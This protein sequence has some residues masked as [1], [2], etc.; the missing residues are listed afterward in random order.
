VNRRPQVAA[1]GVAD[2]AKPRL[3][4]DFFEKSS[5]ARSVFTLRIVLA[6]SERLNAIIVSPVSSA[7]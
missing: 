6:V 1:T 7:D 3:H 2:P 4:D 5:A